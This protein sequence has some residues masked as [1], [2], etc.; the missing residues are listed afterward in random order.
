M[1]KKLIYKIKQND[2]KENIS[3]VLDDTKKFR[4]IARTFMFK[5]VEYK[6]LKWNFKAFHNQFEFTEATPIIQVTNFLKGSTKIY[7]LRESPF[8][9]YSDLQNSS[10]AIFTDK[11]YLYNFLELLES[12][13]EEENKYTSELQMIKTIRN[14]RSF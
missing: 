5:G 6:I 8:N 12:V 11:A 10:S 7:D 3:S 2:R 13:I 4:G 1:F 14:K 9:R